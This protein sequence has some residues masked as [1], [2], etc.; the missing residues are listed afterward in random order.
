[1]P[2]GK[3]ARQR[4]AGAGAVLRVVDGFDFVGIADVVAQAEPVAQADAEAVAA[5]G[6]GNVVGFVGV[7]LSPRALWRTQQRQHQDRGGSHLELSLF[8]D[9]G[10]GQAPNV[11]ALR[12]ASSPRPA[13]SSGGSESA[14]GAD[15]L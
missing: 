9:V 11:S 12:P 2:D 5:F 3:P 10:R 4:R 8:G 1:Q 7:L 15:S 14:R 6:L 13:S